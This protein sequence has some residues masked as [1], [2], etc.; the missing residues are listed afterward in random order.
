MPQG[1]F[2]VVVNG[3]RVN[4][5]TYDHVL[6]VDGW[7]DEDFI[8]VIIRHCRSDGTVIY[9][10]T[11]RTPVMGDVNN[12]PGRIQAGSAT[13]LGGLKTGDAYPQEPPHIRTLPVTPERNW[14]P[15][16]VWEGNLT[17]GEDVVFITPS[18]WEVDDGKGLLQR[19]IEGQKS[20]DDQ[21]GMKAKEIF[22]QVLPAWKWIFDAVSLGIQTQAAILQHTGDPGDRPI[23]MTRNP[24]P[25]GLK[26]IFDP[27]VIVLTYDSAK[28]LTQTSS[29]GVPGLLTL[30]YHDDASLGDGD[31]TLYLQ[32]EEVTPPAPDQWQHVGHANDV[33]AMTAVDNRLVCATGDGGLWMR[34]PQ[35]F[36]IDWLRVGHAN[37]LTAMAALNGELWC[38]TTDNGLHVR[39]PVPFE[40]PW[41]RVGHANNVVGLTGGSDGQLY[42]AT[43]ANQLWMRPPD[44]ADVNWTV[45]GE[46]NN[47]TAMTASNDQ[48]LA[49]ADG[50]I[51]RRPAGTAPGPWNEAGATPGQVR[52]LAVGGGRLWAATADNRLWTREL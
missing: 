45:I 18:A 28:L 43:T 21:F 39:P 33:A 44:H 50:R 27:P 31:Y 13:S 22:G 10:T 40:V 19:F 35:L 25:N 17:A 20:I 26:Y 9:T 49:A 42:C 14:P 5:Q 30:P 41:S 11:P 3:F 7:A 37:G 2:R 46:G 23:G 34:E 24:D 8:Q 51:W 12:L 48:L 4:K 47:V 32:V 16:S 15:F 1:R 38:T 36:N 6:N 52:G 29:M